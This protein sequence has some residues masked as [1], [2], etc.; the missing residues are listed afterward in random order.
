MPVLVDAWPEDGIGL[1]ESLERV[2]S[3]L[4]GVFRKLLLLSGERVFPAARAAWRVE[5]GL[6]QAAFLLMDPWATPFDAGSTPRSGLVP[7]S[8]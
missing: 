3:L 5:E 4:L 7:A 8:D 6:S 1:L 2:G